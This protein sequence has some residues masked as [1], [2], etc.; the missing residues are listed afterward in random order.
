MLCVKSETASL[1]K[2]LLHRP[3][4][5]MAFL[6]KGNMNDYLFD[7]LPDMD[8]AQKE[9]DVFS[10]ILRDNGVETVYL[11]DLMKEVLDNNDVRDSFIKDFLMMQDCDDERIFNDLLSIKDNRE[12]LEKTVSG[13]DG[14]L[15]AVPNLYFTRD[16][17]TI[18]GKG[19]ALYN[20]HTDVRRR[21]TV[22]G[23]YVNR[24]HP[25]FKAV[26]Y[27]DPGLP[28]QIEGGDV[29]LLSDDCIAIGISERT[30]MNAAVM[31]ARNLIK[32]GIIR[33]ALAMEI[34][35]K[36]ACM[37]L[38]TVFTRFSYNK[39]VIF[40]EVYKTL[41]LK[42]IDEYDIKD[43]SDN[44]ETALCSILDIDDLRLLQCYDP[45]EQWN[46]ACNSLCIGPDKI[47][48]Y[49]INEEINRKYIEAGATL[50][51]I[52]SKELI[53][54]RGGPHCMSMPLIRKE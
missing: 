19:M 2:V 30:T 29:L 5:E 33:K 27:Y 49:D 28:Y 39:F 25:D 17:F 14:R 45:K 12:L 16:T 43:V 15:K 23:E 8:T 44:L 6:N 13:F 24:Y 9:H 54:G 35:S 51:T 48:V 53:K 26:K 18:I 40:N 52:P 10:Q 47:I 50:Y 41:K 31:L 3:G 46:D 21:E 20:M 37:H 11:M 7:E 22:Y 36:R 42:L 4:K 1:K 38:D 32:D 34:P